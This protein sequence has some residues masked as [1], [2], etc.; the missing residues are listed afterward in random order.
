MTFGDLKTEVEVLVKDGSFAD[1]YGDYINEAL[2]EAVD[3][4]NLP[5]L[6]R[7]DAVSTVVGQNYVSLVESAL[8]FSGKLRRVVKSADNQAVRIYQN[9]EA[10][11]DYGGSEFS[12]AGAVE[13]VALEGKILWYT[14][15]PEVAEALRVVY[16][17]NPPLLSDDNDD[18]ELI[19]KELHRGLLV[20]GA[21]KSI[22]AIIEEG[23]EETQKVNSLW[24][25]GQFEKSMLRFHEYL[26]RRKQHYISSYWRV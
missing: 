18:C 6:K 8:D 20:Y 12:T 1:K 9:L 3:R 10:L 2:L 4:V 15:V 7:V 25:E 24:V 19:P 5:D 14:K 11:F 21:A 13:A 26:G 17:Q 22:F 16:F 23:L